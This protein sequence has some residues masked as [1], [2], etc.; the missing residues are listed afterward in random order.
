MPTDTHLLIKISPP[1]RECRNPKKSAARWVALGLIEIG[2]LKVSK[3][4]QNRLSDM[5]AFQGFFNDT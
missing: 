4:D 1:C 2:R 3:T 5:Y